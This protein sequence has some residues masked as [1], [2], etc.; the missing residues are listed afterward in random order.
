MKVHRILLLAALLV[1]SFPGLGRAEKYADE[2]FAPNE[3]HDRDDKHRHRSRA[4][5]MVQAGEI[6]AGLI[7]LAG[8]IAMRRRSASRREN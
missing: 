4:P 7:G 8:Y 5:E 3:D 1:L 6:A 2:Q